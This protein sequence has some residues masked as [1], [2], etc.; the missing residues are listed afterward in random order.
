MRSTA[1]DI[2]DEISHITAYARYRK[3]ATIRC[4]RPEAMRPSLLKIKVMPTL[5]MTHAQVP[6]NRALAHGRISRFLDNI[7]PRETLR[8]AFRFHLASDAS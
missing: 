7:V 3:V 4:G 2:A 5:L 1:A 6:F 8:R